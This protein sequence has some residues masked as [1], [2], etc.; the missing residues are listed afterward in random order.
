M[1]GVWGL[2]ED[3]VEQELA[4]LGEEIETGICGGREFCIFFF[5][6]S[7]GLPDLVG[8]WRKGGIL[9][10]DCVLLL[11]FLVV[12]LLGLGEVKEERV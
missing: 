7:L 9:M 2:F 6:G 1:Q 5:M 11:L 10:G 12:F 8:F 4:F 3:G